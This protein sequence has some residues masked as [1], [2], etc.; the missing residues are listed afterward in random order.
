[1]KWLSEIIRFRL[2]HNLYRHFNTASQDFTGWTPT[3]TG[4][5]RTLQAGH[6]Q[7]Q[8]VSRTQVMDYLVL[9][10]CNICMCTTHATL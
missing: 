10:T 9:S 5:S 3:I 1:M 7:L 2:G 6:P 8:G 4:Y